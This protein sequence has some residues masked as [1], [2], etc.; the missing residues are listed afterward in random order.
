MLLA[1]FADRNLSPLRLVHYFTLIPLSFKD[2]R[3]KRFPRTD[4]F[5]NLPHRKVMIYF[6]QKGKTKLGSPISFWREHAP[7]NTLNLKNRA[8]LADKAIVSVSP[9]VL[10]LDL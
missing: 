2:V 6:C 1:F 5:L 8:S 10:Q 4:F 7:K 3:A 9:K